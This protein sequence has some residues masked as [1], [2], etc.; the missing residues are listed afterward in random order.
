MKNILRPVFVLAL[1][2]TA[3]C[4]ESPTDETTYPSG[5]LSFTYAS[6]NSPLSGTFAAIGAISPDAEND[7]WAAAVRQDGGAV[8]MGNQVSGSAENVALVSLPN[9]AVGNTPVTE[10]CDTACASVSFILEKTVDGTTRSYMC[11]MTSGTISVG[12]LTNSR[13]TGTF[14]GTGYCS[15]L[16]DDNAPT[17]SITNGAFDTPVVLSPIIGA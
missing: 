5:S 8:M 10:E 16:E 2:L 17:I 3:A 9:A 7:T 14:S 15:T 11:D 4:D 12:T 6:D 1:A 13:I